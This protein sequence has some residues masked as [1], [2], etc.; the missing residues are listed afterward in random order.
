[1]PIL[2]RFPIGG[3]K[4]ID[5]VN[6]FGVSWD[7]SSS[8]AWT[9]TDNAASFADPNPYVSGASAYSSKFDKYMPW[10]GIVKETI[11]GVGVCVKI[12]KFW[13]K[14][15]QNGNGLK[16]QIAD[17]AAS[18]FSV[19]PAHMN[20]GDGVGERN[21]V[22]IGRYWCTTNAYKSVTGTATK[23]SVSRDT[24]RSGVHSLGST[25][26]Q[27]DFAMVLTIWLLYLVEFANWDSQTKIGYGCVHVTPTS[28]ANQYNSGA[29]DSL[30]YHTGTTQTSRTSYGVTQYRW[31]EDL[32]GRAYQYID[33]CYYTSSGLNIILN[34]SQFI[35]TQSRGTLVGTV[36]NGFPIAFTVINPSGLFPLFLPSTAGGSNT[37]YTTDSWNFNSSNYQLFLGNG[38]SKTLNEGLFHI[39]A[40]AN[41]TNSS[42]YA[43]R[44]MVLP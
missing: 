23:T 35:S 22:Y 15:T 34:P 29:T 14:L 18:G 11:D 28:T 3:E 21:Y 7:G 6:I 30:P 44:L 38:G 42:T 32:W 17:Y 20:R 5:G 2:N 40:V 4:I 10:R 25:V 31:I 16:I 39:Q 9:R 12:P 41:G 19:S 36:A 24:S 26:W 33:G 13:Y 43:C 27:M 8:P 1:M 37:T